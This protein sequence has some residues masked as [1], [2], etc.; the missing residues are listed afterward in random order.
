MQAFEN[1]ILIYLL[2]AVLILFPACR[3][4]QR[5]CIIENKS[6]FFLHSSFITDLLSVTMELCKMRTQF[7]DA[8]ASV[9]TVP[10]KARTPYYSFAYNELF[11]KIYHG[12]NSG[13]YKQE[14]TGY[15]MVS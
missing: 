11:P 5:S 15:P 3:V 8:Q 4:N 12:K 1:K 14:R 2:K 7:Q 10:S 13:I 9:N 6:P